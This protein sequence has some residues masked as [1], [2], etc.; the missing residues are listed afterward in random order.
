MMK[1]MP[2]MNRKAHAM[3]PRQTYAHPPYF[4]LVLAL[5]ML[6]LASTGNARKPADVFKRKII[7]STKSFPSSFKSD[8]AFVHYMKRNNKKRLVYPKSNQ[9][10]VRFMAFFSKPIRATEFTA[11]LY[12][13]TD[14][15]RLVAT[16]P[17]S[18]NQR[19][20]RILASAFDFE[21]SE[22]PEEHQYRLMIAIGNQALAETRFTI[23]E[24]PSNR[25]KRK[26]RE[27]SL[28]KSRNIDFTRKKNR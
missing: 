28:R 4:G 21:V 12:D 13:L 20:T 24:S 8:K 2:S 11:L 26:A 15:G 14:R 25:V 19:V 10:T 27:R 6:C 1:G 7:I 3:L 16:V 5:F 22:F 17:V 9:M 18:P 23:K